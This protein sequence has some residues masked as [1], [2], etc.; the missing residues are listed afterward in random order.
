M[1]QM[2]LTVNTQPAALYGHLLVTDSFESC[3]AVH[4]SP[5]IFF[6]SNQPTSYE[7]PITLWTFMFIQNGGE[8]KIDV[9]FKWMED[10]TDHKIGR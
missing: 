3:C 10:A 4:A 8:K 6:L 5:Y 2:K 7:H 1:S 9:H